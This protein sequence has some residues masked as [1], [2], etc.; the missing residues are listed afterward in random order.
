LIGERLVGTVNVKTT[1]SAYGTSSTTAYSE[2]KRGLVDASELTALGVAAEQA[3][4]I[5]ADAVIGALGG[6]LVEAVTA[7][8]K[9]LDES[10]GSADPKPPK[11][12]VQFRPM[13]LD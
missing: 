13:R 6:H 7:G 5:V 8:A 11:Q 3:A 2:S 9:V 10:G 12:A 1:L 4:T